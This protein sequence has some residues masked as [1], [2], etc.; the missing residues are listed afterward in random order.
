MQLL[1]QDL[2]YDEEQ[3]LATFLGECADDDAGMYPSMADG[4]LTAVISGPQFFAPSIWLPKVCSIK[5][6]APRKVGQ[7]LSMTE[8]LPLILRRYNAVSRALQ[9]GRVEPLYAAGEDEDGIISNELAFGELWC[10]GYLQGIGL[11][12][13]SW[14][15]LIKDDEHSQLLDDIFFLATPFIARDRDGCVR[16][17]YSKVYEEYT[18]LTKAERSDIAKDLTHNIEAIY[19]YWKAERSSSSTPVQAKPK[20]GRNDTCPCGSGNKYKR[21]CGK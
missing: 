8:A 17:E 12:L 3:R 6:D 21:C 16:P 13:N 19:A 18:S 10:D 20:V 5:S 9:A 1:N 15:R 4:F 7:T 2:S 14:N 11:E